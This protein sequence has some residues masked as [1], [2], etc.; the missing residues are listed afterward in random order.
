[1][2]ILKGDQKLNT[3]QIM[4]LIGKVN[5][6]IYARVSTTDQAK[7]GFSIE[8]QLD[9]CKERAMS[10]FGYKD[11]EMIALVEPGGMGDDPNR[12]ALNHALYLLQ[13]GLGKKFLVLHPDRLTRDNT[14]QGVIS[15]RI[16]GMGVDIEF[17]EFEVNPNDPESMLMY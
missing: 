14:L 17:I 1:M 7:K 6:L 12:P 4:S 13:K 16:W 11:S 3:E 15:R 5:A 8:S 10:K 9:R 2:L